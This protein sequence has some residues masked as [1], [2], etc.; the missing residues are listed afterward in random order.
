[1]F[2]S[3][4][5]CE[6]EAFSGRQ[7]CVLHC[8]KQGYS[9]DRDELHL[10]NA[11]FHE[12][13]EYIISQIMKFPKN[14]IDERL[15]RDQLSVGNVSS[16]SPFMAQQLRES[17]IYLEQ[18]W[19]PGH[20]SRD[21]LDY[22]KLL[23]CFGEI[24]F[25]R[26]KF[27]TYELGLKKSKLFFLECTFEENWYLKNHQLYDNFCSVLYQ[28]CIFKHDVSLAFEVTEKREIDNSLFD[29]CLF[30]KKL[31]LG[32][33]HFKSPIFINGSMSS[34]EL[35]PINYLE[36]SNCQI[37]ADF[38]LSNYKIEVLKIVQ[39]SF[40]SELWLIKSKIN[41][42]KIIASQF[43]KMVNLQ[44]N[45]FEDFVIDGATFREFTTFENSLFGSNQPSPKISTKFEF[46][47]FLSF[48]SFSG[49]KFSNGLNLRR[50]NM[51]ETP[52]FLGAEMN[53]A[54][55]DRETYRI[56]KN[57]FDKVGNFIEA[58]HFYRFEMLKRGEELS[59]NRISWERVIFLLYKITSDFG[60][61][62]SRP[63]IW[64]ATMSFLYSSLV[65]SKKHNWLYEII[66][67]QLSDLVDKASIVLN[68]IAKGIIPFKR[69]LE[70]GMEFLSLV[71]YIIFTS[72][73][74][75]VILAIK[76]HTKR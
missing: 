7:E 46:V 25:D 31:Y 14:S 76:R 61:S 11:F 3:N 51:K 24:H 40:Q 48:C 37:E 8:E 34:N 27:S 59:N 38:I 22:E 54:L 15:L 44:E 42:L 55:T 5:T 50:V 20:D 13:L 19:F 21:I 41:Q 60:Q 70:P 36:V 17:S 33:C 71:F 74:W 10:L 32:S 64:I 9:K 49:A 23:R 72:L 75:L 69:W 30:L 68:Y 16:V 29:N 1:M 39:S 62:V 18:I 47:T 56:V 52:N 73:I 26:C 53:A 28:H 67:D 45:E 35:S 57:S 58:N 2:C 4:P 65:Y 63:L 66:P 12:I 43:D 6:R